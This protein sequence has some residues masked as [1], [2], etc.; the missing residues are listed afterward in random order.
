MGGIDPLQQAMGQFDM[1]AQLI[2][3]VARTFPGTEQMA[4]QMMEI[5]DQWRQQALVSTTPQSS[6]MP[7]ADMMM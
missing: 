7:G 2:S 6:S 4:S 3:D 5:L 1:L